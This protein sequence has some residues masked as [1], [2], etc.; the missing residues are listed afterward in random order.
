MEDEKFEEKKEIIKIQFQDS[1]NITGIASEYVQKITEKHNFYGDVYE[2]EN[3]ELIAS[4]ILDED[5]TYEVLE[6]IKE[7]GEDLF[8]ISNNVVSIYILGSPH[9]ENKITTHIIESTADM[10]IK[11]S[12]MEYS[13]AYEIYWHIKGLVEKKIKLSKDDQFA[14]SMIPMMGPPED[15][16]YLRIECLKIWKEAVNKGMIE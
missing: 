2:T 4:I 14:L 7:Y 15:K 1:R 3:K 16:R 8:K 5:F 13:D 10:I 11:F 12:K 6:K 9:I